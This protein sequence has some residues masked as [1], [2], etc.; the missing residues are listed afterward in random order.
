MRDMKNVKRIVVKVGTSTLTYDSGKVNFAKFDK[1]T[2]VL[3]DLLN[4]G[5]EIVLVSSGAIGIGVD[6]LR[7]E[8]MPKTTRD[9][10]A[11]AAV[12]QSELMH[13]YSKLFSEYNHVVAQILMTKDVVDDKERRKYIIG[14]F[15]AL[16]KKGI[17]PIVNEN[18]S[19]SVEEIN[20]GDNDTL[21]AVIAGITKAD[22]LIVLSDI[23]GYFTKDPR[24]SDNAK[25]I[26]EIKEITEEI[27][28]NAGGEGTRRGTGGM[29]TKLE[30]A[31][32]CTEKYKI[33]MVIANGKDPMN[34]ERIVKG[35]DVGTIFLPKGDK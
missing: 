18:D 31:R 26:S 14:T 8:K 25:L 23:D 16:L 7:M 1:L 30:A 29:K 3:S 9:K 35:K 33:P 4:Q 32:L 20:F 12:G 24:K 19:I 34:I 11:V 21:S 6:K 2:F 13:L 15:E 17:I 27:E 5:Y 28:N 22:L 10:Q